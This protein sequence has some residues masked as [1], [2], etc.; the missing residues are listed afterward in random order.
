MLVGSVEKVGYWPKV[1]VILRLPKADKSVV[2]YGERLQYN[3]RSKTLKP[4]TRA[5]RDFLQS[6]FSGKIYKLHMHTHT[7]VN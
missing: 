6:H 5:R 3:A 2:S 4:I 1:K 7:H